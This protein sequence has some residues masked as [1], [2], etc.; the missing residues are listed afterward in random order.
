MRSISCTA[1]AAEVGI[2]PASVYCILT[3]SLGKRKVCAKWIPHMLNNDRR[4]MHVLL[5]NTHL[6]RWRNEGNA[7]LDRILTVGE[8]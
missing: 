4:A 5:A 7:F 2:S 1:I 3:N 6:Q 8:S